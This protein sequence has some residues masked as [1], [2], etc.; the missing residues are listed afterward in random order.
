MKKIKVKKIV[1]VV[2]ACVSA[3]ALV[4]CTFQIVQPRI[5]GSASGG[6]SAVSI[7]TGF[8][9]LDRTTGPKSLFGENSRAIG[10]SEGTSTTVNYK[11][12]YAYPNNKGGDCP[13]FRIPSITTI[14]AGKHKGKLFATI[15]ARWGGTADLA[16]RADA[17]GRCGS[18]DAKVWEQPV[19]VATWD[20]E[21]QGQPGSYPY[22]GDPSV[23]SDANGHLYAFANMGY[24]A[25]MQSGWSGTAATGSPYVRINGEWYLLLRA[26]TDKTGNKEGTWDAS[27]IDESTGVSKN[28]DTCDQSKKW[29]LGFTDNCLSGPNE[30]EH[31][32][33]KAPEFTYAAPVKGGEIVKINRSGNI[34]IV[35]GWHSNLWMDE[36]YMLWEKF[37]NGR[38]SK[39]LKVVRVR[40]TG[41]GYSA[42]SRSISGENDPNLVDCHVL[43]PLSPFQPWTGRMYFTFAKSTDGG[44][45]WTRPKDITYMTAPDEKYH[46]GNKDND[47]QSTYHTD[48]NPGIAV[49]SPTH[50]T[51]LRYD[52]EWT[53]RLIHTAYQDLGGNKRHA[54]AFWT[55]DGGQTWDCSDYI[56]HDIKT[57]IAHNNHISSDK[58]ESVI[59]ETPDGTLYMVNRSMGSRGNFTYS[60]SKDGGATW[61]DKDLMGSG[62]NAK[63]CAPGDAFGNIRSGRVLPAALNLYKSVT[64]D[65]NP[66]VAFLHG[67]RCILV[68]LEK[69]EGDPQWTFNFKWNNSA[70][71][72][73]PNFECEGGNYASMA[74]MENGDIACFYEPAGTSV[75]FA[76]A[77]LARE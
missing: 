6:T 57:D 35:P 66:L 9:S 3:L 64:P 43:N 11:P 76:I 14:L 34:T 25:G 37:E 13:R 8:E 41:S 29:G 27:D 26:N 16:S 46:M 42:V 65:G 23:G 18:A 70:I 74:E 77:R 52:H 20:V 30:S 58:G 54:W 12:S 40:A 72:A 53:G 15:D 71:C 17:V 1:A 47:D 4:A 50:P 33:S 45:T 28:N 56:G 62:E 61:T 32:S 38:Y 68:A 59:L 7:V 5:S 48:W 22:F 2:V 51:P 60:E 21:T 69:K 31:K 36:Y 63:Y 67:K 49:V 24:R 10:E 44:K 39:P 73:L 55:D 75:Q 19:G